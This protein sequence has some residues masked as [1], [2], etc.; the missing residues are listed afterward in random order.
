[1]KVTWI[2]LLLAQNKI[3]QP[4]KR[5]A[6]QVLIDVRYV[7]TLKCAITLTELKTHNELAD[8]S[9]AQHGNRLSV[10]PVAKEQ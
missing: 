9:L 4:K 3:L 7:R 8:G 1:M 5:S 10:M 6:E 2:S